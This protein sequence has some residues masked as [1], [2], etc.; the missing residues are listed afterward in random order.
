MTAPSP[1]IVAS[2][3]L[4]AYYPSHEAYLDAI[5]REMRNEYQAIHR[6]GLILQIDA[7]D[8]AMDRVMMFRDLSDAEFVKACERGVTA[9][10]AGIEGIPREAVRLHICYGNW[11]GPHIHDIALEKILPALYQAKVGALSIE[12]S[13]PRHAHEYAALKAR[14]LP[15]DMILIP[16]VIETTSNFVEHPEVVARRIEEAVAVVGDRERVLASTDCGFGTFTNREWVIEPAVW[17]KL[18]ALREGADIASARLWGR[19][20]A[21]GV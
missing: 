11:E 18:K 13:N 2:T 9:I 4:N 3:M 5:A 17:L 19:G 16:G 8:L 7:P 14:P 12:F 21:L 1:G 15:K 10:N 20:R 6:A